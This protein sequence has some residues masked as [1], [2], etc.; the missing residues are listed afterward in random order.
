MR[1]IH[2]VTVSKN[3]YFGYQKNVFVEDHSGVLKLHHI[4]TVYFWGLIYII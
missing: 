4:E 1:K 3:K 2:K